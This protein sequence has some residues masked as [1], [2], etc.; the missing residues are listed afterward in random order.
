MKDVSAHISYKLGI[1]LEPYR[2]PQDPNYSKR[3]KKVKMESEKP[4]ISKGC[5]TITAQ[6]PPTPP[7]TRFLIAD[8]L[9]LTSSASFCL[10]ISVSLEEV[11]LLL[12]PELDV[13]LDDDADDDDGFMIFGSGEAGVPLVV[14]TD[15]RTKRSA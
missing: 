8:V 9:P 5:P 15:T 2:H 12:E 10:S 14:A 3:R 1:M 11:L 4:T 13:I 6:T 7:A